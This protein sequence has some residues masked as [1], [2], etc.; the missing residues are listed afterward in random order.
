[1]VN[2]NLT[3]TEAVWWLTMIV[4]IWKLLG[5][6]Q[7][8]KR[9]AEKETLR[10]H[11]PW[12]YGHVIFDCGRSGNHLLSCKYIFLLAAAAAAG[13]GCVLWAWTNFKNYDIYFFYH[14]ISALLLFLLGSFDEVH[15]GGFASKYIKT[16]FFM[17]VHPPVC[18]IIHYMFSIRNVLCLATT[19]SP[20]YPFLL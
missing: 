16:R 18:H 10:S 8:W 1:M 20:L 14:R 11:L 2:I 9:R 5:K 6:E 3:T 19:D 7:H 4:A 15:F 17:D 13:G 12:H